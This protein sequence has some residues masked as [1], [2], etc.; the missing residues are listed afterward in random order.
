VRWFSVPKALELTEKKRDREEE[1]VARL[2]NHREQ[3]IAK[4][5]IAH[6]NRIEFL[7]FDPYF[8]FGVTAAGVAGVIFGKYVLP[9]LGQQ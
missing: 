2:F 1:I 5:I 8:M 4:H 9:K 6:R 3:R 7:A